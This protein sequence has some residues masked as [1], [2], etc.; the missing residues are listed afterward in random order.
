[1]GPGAGIDPGTSGCQSFEATDFL[2]FRRVF[3]PCVP[4]ILWQ[5]GVT[6]DLGYTLKSSLNGLR[7]LVEVLLQHY[8]P[9]HEVTLYE[10]A[11]Y[12]NC[13]PIIQRVALA[14][15]PE[16]EV[17]PSSTLYLPPKALGVPDHEMVARLGL[18]TYFGEGSDDPNRFLEE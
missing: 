9:T 17:T 3:D 16:A 14:G 13:E 15:V 8:D 6:G 2:I 11:Q 5:I 4:L 1:M 18:G 7:I 10:A 12:L